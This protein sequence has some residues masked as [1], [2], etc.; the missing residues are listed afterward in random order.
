[1]TSARATLH[2][3]ALFG[4]A[5]G[6]AMAVAATGTATDPVADV[7]P[8]SPSEFEA[9]VEG[10]TVYFE[11]DGA[12]F[13]AEEFREDRGTTWR[14][15]D[16]TC[17]EGVWRPHGAQICFFYGQETEVLCWRML[18]DEQGLFARLL[19]EGPDAGL[20]LRITGRDREPLLCGET[21]PDI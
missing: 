5:L 3:L 14:F 12:P 9:Y 20:E 11:R 15:S 4:A 2:R 10:Y 8:V 17:A 1:M 16:G 19:G 13:G 21:G 7:T 6:L 18:R